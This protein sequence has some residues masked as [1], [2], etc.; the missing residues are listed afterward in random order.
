MSVRKISFASNDAEEEGH[1]ALDP[2][3]LLSK[4][5][6]VLQ[7]RHGFTMMA[8]AEPRPDALSTDQSIQAEEDFLQRREQARTYQDPLGMDILAG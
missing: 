3:L 2:I 4:S 5:I 1:P 6:S 7:A 8:A